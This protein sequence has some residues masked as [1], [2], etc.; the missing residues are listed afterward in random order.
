MKILVIG[1]GNM[2]LTYAHGMAQSDLLREKDLMILDT[3]AEKLAELRA[4]GTFEVYEKL[5]DCLPQAVIVFIAVKTYNSDEVFYGI[6][7]YKKPYQ[8]FVSNIIGHTIINMKK[9]IT[10]N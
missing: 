2:G 5:E 8:I 1:A 3:S 6:N 10:M 9:S 7:Q 4:E